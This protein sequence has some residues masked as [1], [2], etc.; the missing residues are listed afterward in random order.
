MTAAP[1]GFDASGVLTASVRLPS[2]SYPTREARA[3]FYDE[4]LERLRALPGVESVAATLSLPTTEPGRLGMTIE[5]VPTPATGQP[6]VDRQLVS[7]DYFSALR[8][9]LLQGRTF[10][11][12]DLR[13]GARVAVI[14]AS[15]A[16][17][18]WPRGNALG[19][20]MRLGP[21]PDA[22][23]TEVIGIVGDVRNDLTRPS[24][25]PMLYL[26]TR[27]AALPFT[28]VLVRTTGSPLALV[29][30]MERALA[31]I[32]DQLPLQRPATLSAVV[33]DG[34]TGRRLPAVLMVAFGV[35]A[36]VLASVGVYA[37]F[38]NLT[39]SRERE[40]GVRMAMGSRP[41]DIAVLVLRQGMGWMALGLIGGAFGIVV[42]VRFVQS[43]LY[44]VAPFDPLTL[45]VAVATLLVC[46]AVAL[47]IPVRQATRVDPV[48]ALRA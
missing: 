43:L 2:V 6:F 21:N 28:N 1:L 11:G 33:G 4:F 38:A 23:W 42:V 10:G 47:L 45:S 35:L 25:E 32:D 41:G 31:E 48:V 29:L 22:P 24:A 20:R 46:A 15:M 8:I 26:P 36:L 14:S 18:Y 39:A 13:D 44:G 9:P 17:R 16:E 7:D 27:Q 40:F 5:G 37:M 3:A 19:A 30:P 34:L 12:E